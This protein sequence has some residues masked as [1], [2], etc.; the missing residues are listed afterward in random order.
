MNKNLLLIISLL[1]STNFLADASEFQAGAQMGAEET[2][3][4]VEEGQQ[5]VVQAPQQQPQPRQFLFVLGRRINPQDVSFLQG[6]EEQ[7][8]PEGEI[9]I[10]PAEVDV[11]DP[12]QEFLVTLVAMPQGEQAMDLAADQVVGADQ[13]RDMESDQESDMESE[14]PIGPIPLQFD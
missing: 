13:E 6:H 5:F 14:G 3:M 11:E 2:K 7:K 4:D 12:S 8:L 1:L 10:A 9:D